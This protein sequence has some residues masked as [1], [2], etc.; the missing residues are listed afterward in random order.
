MS[1]LPSESPNSSDI[2][3][4]PKSRLQI[5][6]QEARPSSIEGTPLNLKNTPKI[7]S[8]E[9]SRARKRRASAMETTPNSSNRIA[10]KRDARQDLPDNRQDPSLNVL[11]MPDTSTVCANA[12]GMLVPKRISTGFGPNGRGGIEDWKGLA[13]V[14]RVSLPFFHETLHDEN[15]RSA[16]ADDADYSVSEA[17]D[18]ITN[19]SSFVKEHYTDHLESSWDT[20]VS[21]SARKGADYSNSSATENLVSPCCSI[22]GLTGTR[23]SFR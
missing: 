14:S 10:V 4:S 12:E 1:R 11:N 22:V 6:S 18:C 2:F 8:G 23:W 3:G 17:S 7:L 13:E 21:V 5:F 19:L 20:F 16:I 9:E 15:S